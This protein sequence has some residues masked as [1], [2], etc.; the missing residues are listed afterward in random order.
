MITITKTASAADTAVI[1]ALM[2]FA[3]SAAV[4]IPAIGIREDEVFFAPTMFHPEKSAYSVK[5]GHSYFPDMLN[6]YVGADKSYL[7][8]PILK[9]I[10][11]SAWTLR[12]PVVLIGVINL[13]LLFVAVR[14]F[15]NEYV[16]AAL[17]CVIATDPLFMLTT[18]LD[19]GPVA[20]QHLCFAVVLACLTRPRPLIMA[21]FAAMGVA[22]WD[23][24]TAIWTLAALAVSAAVFLP[25]K[26][27]QH[28]TLR[29]LGIAV[30][31]FVL[32][33]FPFLIFNLT[34]HWATL[35]ENAVFSTEGIVDKVRGMYAVLDG[36]GAFDWLV[37]GGTPN[38][39]T[40][41]PY[42][43]AA[44]AIL[45]FRRRVAPV[46]AA[47]LLALFT[48]FLTWL[49][50]L[51]VKNGGASL[52]HV[53]LVWPWPHLFMICVLG[54]AFR[55]PVFLGIVAALLL[56]NVVMTGLYA[57]RAYVFGPDQGWSDA[58]FGLRAVLSRNRE[59]ITLDWGIRDT[60][61]FLTRGRI[62]IEDRT[63]SGLTDDD[64][65]DI[66]KKQ[67]LTHVNGEEVIAG[68][69]ARFEAAI[70]KA[71][72]VPIVDRVLSDRRGRP[73]IVSLHCAHAV[74]THAAAN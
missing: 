33:N 55:K 22:L 58:T 27:R 60:G 4:F 7:Y 54:F 13:W 28:L 52:H 36:R 70:H 19:W 73:L 49:A 11:P 45:L 65:R 29:N 56:S 44:A 41:T 39:Y 25:D 10:R 43:I 26:I 71:G 1:F 18:A 30:A 68:N 66:D 5:I 3:L 17:A 37:R 42:A 38:W 8:K 64:L 53:I 9:R 14:R 74:L 31:G 48:G 24:G 63:F 16:A 47:A 12:V 51:F 59:F 72:F 62:P 46:R 61:I 15:T 32:G 23:K 34:H 50:M 2:F 40:L 35:G 6:S 67:F 69:N 57:Q 21:G 20:V